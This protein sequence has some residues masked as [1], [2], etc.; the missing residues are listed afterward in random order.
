MPLSASL[1][2]FVVEAYDDYAGRLLHRLSQNPD[3][4]VRRFATARACLAQL[5]ETPQ[6]V[7]L[8]ARL[9]DVCVREVLRCLRAQ[10][11]QATLVVLSAQ[12]DAD[13]AVAMLRNGAHDFLVKDDTAL[14]R[15]WTVAN[16]VARQV[17]PPAAPGRPAAPAQVAILGQHP[18]MR[19]LQHLI[20]KAAATHITVSIGGETGTG[21]ELVARAIHQQSARAQQ[22]FVA[23]NMAAIPHELLESE[24]FGHEK[25]AFTGAAARRIGRLEEAHGGTLFLDEIADL[26]LSLQAK[27]LRVLQ[28]REVT[29]LGGTKA[30]PFDVRLVVATHRDL[31]AEVRAG[32]FREDLYYRLLGLP[33]AL[34]PLRERGDDV[35]LLADAFNRN[36]CQQQHLP[37]RPLAAS[38]RRL[39]RTH[40]FPGN[41]REL[42]AVVERAAVLADGNCLEADDFLMTDAP[43]VADPDC[44]HSLRAQTTAIVQRCLAEV[45][46][47]VQAAAQRLGISRSTIYRMVQHNTGLN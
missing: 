18:A 16:A 41:V 5:A 25:G 46:G 23:L 15:L 6:L 33:I 22:P 7:V 19:Q 40:P 37:L 32:H 30:V 9:P 17:P 4:R 24:L 29:R 1:S 14:D 12:N 27:L 34:P 47:D 39:L 21:K 26:S 2:I 31:L 44:L 3:H 20:A 11:P 43:L 35:L 42:R 13:T 38:A 10:L 28:E 36:F 45:G 8:D